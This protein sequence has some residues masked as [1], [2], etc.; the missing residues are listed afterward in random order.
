MSRSSF[1][2]LS[3]CSALVALLLL[4]AC[5]RVS[6]PARKADKIVTMEVTG[7]CK[8]GKCCGWY[9]NWYGRP[10]ISY[11]KN[12]GKKKAVG[13][14]ARGTKAAPGTIAADTSKYPFGTIMYIDGYGYGVVEDRGGAIKGEKIDLFFTSHEQALQWGRVKKNVRVWKTGR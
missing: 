1:I 9:R 2:S 6:A 10:T 13:I 7:Y 11:G 5:S 12:K 14:T 8:C 4:P 3:F